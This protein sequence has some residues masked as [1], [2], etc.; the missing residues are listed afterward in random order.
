[1]GPD[2]RPPRPS[3]EGPG[4]GGPGDA[5][6]EAVRAL[7][8]G[9]L[10]VFPTETVYG[11]GADARDA[12][13]VR[14]IFAAK[15]RPAAQ[16]LTV[17]VG[18]EVDPDEWAVDIPF[19]ARRLMQ[20]LWPGPLTVVLRSRPDVLDVV[21]GGGETVGLRVP[22]EP[23]TLELFSRF[24]GGVAGTSANRHGGPSP[25]SAAEA[26]DAIGDEVAV[27]L[28]GGPCRLG[29]E[30]TIVDLTGPEPAVL[31]EGALPVERIEQVAGEAVVAAPGP[32]AA[33]E[34]EA[35]DR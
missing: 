23:T 1:M 7:R 16:P 10:V 14:R 27:V 22:D 34:H 13:A 15:G 19:A 4:D 35:G 8:E 12:T 25:T 17:H 29:A 26:A 33:G 9:R 31:R 2:E 18:I 30:S 28:D 6:D 3:D 11:V 20:E 21:R 24:G 32:D 5:V